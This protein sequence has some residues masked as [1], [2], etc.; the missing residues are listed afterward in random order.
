MYVAVQT[1]QKRASDLIT[2]GCESPCGCWELNSG[3]LEEQSMLLTA[4]SSL[5]PKGQYL[6]GSG[7]QVQRF[8]PLS[9]RQ[10][11]GSTKAGM[12]LEELRVLHLHL[13]ATR[14]LASSELG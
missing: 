6:I 9:P 5:Q 2:N 7:L 11:H 8:S 1:H 14:R 3:L 12:G 10:E 13:K 4:E